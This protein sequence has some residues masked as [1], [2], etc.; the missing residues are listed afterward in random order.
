[1]TVLTLFEVTGS[2]L[3]VSAPAISGNNSE[4]TIEQ[5]S[6]LVTFTPR[7]PRGTTFQVN[8]YL[9]TEAYNTSQ[10]VW[11]I[12]NPI[13]GTWR[14]SLDGFKTVALP[15]DATAAQVDAALSALPPIDD[16][17]NVTVIKGTGD[18]FNVEFVGALANSNIPQLVAIS[19]LTNANGQSCPISVT[20]STQGTPQVVADTAIA[21]PAITARI[22]NGRLCAIDS[23]DSPGVMLT[24]NSAALNN[25]DPLI[26]DVTFSNVRF[27]SV[28]QVIAPFAFVA[29][30]DSS[31]VCLTDPGLQRLPYDVPIP[32]MWTPAGAATNWRIRAV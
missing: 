6:G 24:A 1:M 32:A 21:L 7:L 3:S 18:S 17:A 23:V 27:N 11:L 12:A 8:D 16:T 31:S 26:Y 2:W 20:V 25:P 9:V 4:P 19:N 5:V 30:E 13:A 22:W 10:Q 15:Y 29:P 14:L 28:D